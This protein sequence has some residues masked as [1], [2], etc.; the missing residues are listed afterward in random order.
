MR[1]AITIF[2]ALVMVLSLTACGGGKA[3][4]KDD[5]ETALKNTDK[6]LSLQQSDNS[7]NE[8]NYSGKSTT[9]T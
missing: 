9:N 2:L 1:K 4:T 5:L 6:E 3:I 7:N 8:F